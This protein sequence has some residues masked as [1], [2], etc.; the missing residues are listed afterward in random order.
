MPRGFFNTSFEEEEVYSR[1]YH[2]DS[3][4]KPRKKRNFK[5]EHRDHPKSNIKTAEKTSL[6]EPTKDFR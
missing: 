1:K 2:D 4:R 3:E 5:G 6:N